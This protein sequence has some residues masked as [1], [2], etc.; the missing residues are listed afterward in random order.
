MRPAVIS[1]E[2]ERLLEEVRPT[3]EL[4][5]LALGVAIILATYLV[6]AM[7]ILMTAD[8]L[9]AFGIGGVHR[10]PVSLLVLLLTFPGLALGS[11]LAVLILHRR[12]PQGLL[13]RNF[14]RF[15]GD[16]TVASTITLTGQVV[17]LAVGFLIFAPVASLPVAIWA[18]W[19]VPVL[20]LI[21]MQ[22]AAEELVFRGYLQQ[23]LAARFR[24][25]WIWWVAPSVLFGLLH[26]DT[27]VYGPN[28]WLVVLD[29]MLIGLIAADLTART[30]NL[31][32]AVGLHFTNNA[33]VLLFVALQGD[34]SGMALHVTPFSAAD[35]S[36]MRLALGGDVVLFG[37]GYAVYLWIMGRWGRA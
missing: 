37:G 24:S 27:Q 25:R 14:A 19:V 28:A 29:T 31:G 26:Y 22:S 2:Y 30:G 17:S 36:M 5:R 3:S 18:M 23:Q 4:W 8:N 34:L 20:A 10:G 21:L 33:V 11:V 32:A 6:V 35:H 12:D 9:G 1:A 16:F 15:R 13:G 7:V